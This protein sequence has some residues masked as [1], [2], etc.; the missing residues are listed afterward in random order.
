MM[1]HYASNIL[2]RVTPN[3][4]TAMFLSFPALEN[5]KKQWKQTL[6]PQ[7]CFPHVSSKTG[8]RKNKYGEKNDATSCK[9][10]F[11]LVH[12]KCFHNNIS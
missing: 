11:R 7:Q 12:P 9:Q 1:S 5:M 3:V 6:C 4:S 2:D 10:Y 8:M